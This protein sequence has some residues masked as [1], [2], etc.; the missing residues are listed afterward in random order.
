M[1]DLLLFGFIFLIPL[2]GT[3]GNIFFGGHSPR[4]PV[5]WDFFL[6]MIVMY[7]FLHKIFS[8]PKLVQISNLRNIKSM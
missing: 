3:V 7:K 6:A 4:V 8:Y 5:G 1:G 2:G